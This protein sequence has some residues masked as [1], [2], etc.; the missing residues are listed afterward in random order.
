MRG[1]KSLRVLRTPPPLFPHPKKGG[2]KEASLWKK[3]KE[4]GSTR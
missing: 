2:G 1:L 3:K 4:K